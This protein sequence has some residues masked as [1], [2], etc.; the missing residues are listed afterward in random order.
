MDARGF[1]LIAK[2]LALAS[3]ELPPPGGQAAFPAPDGRPIVFLGAARDDR[4]TLDEAALLDAVAIYTRD[5]G[6][7]VLRSNERRRPLAEPSALAEISERLRSRNARLA[8]WCQTRADG[9]SVELVV[10]DGRRYTTREAFEKEGPAGPEIY[11]AIALKLRAALTGPE[12]PSPAAP[13][14]RDRADRNAAQPPIGRGAPPGP[15]GARDVT[16]SGAADRARPADAP[17]SAPR[18]LAPRVEPS[19]PSSRPEADP[20]PALARPASPALPSET[21]LAIGPAQPPPHLVSLAVGYALSRPSGSAPWRNA[22]AIHGV[23]SFH[24]R[25]EIDLGL[26]VAP[27]AE[28]DAPTGFVSVTDLPLRLGAR[29][30]RR[31]SVYLLAAGALVGV[32]ALFATATASSPDR[33]TESTRVLAASFGLELLARGPSVRGFAPEVRLFGEVNAPNTRF[34]VR[35]ATALESGALTVGLGL[36][37]AVPAP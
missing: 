32:H 1:A 7:T 15:E 8:F 31:S 22:A 12:P 18:P 13:P 11:R 19:I 30:V 26:E 5:L 33:A 21:S 4:P 36:G 25:A 16:A 34:R 6:V 17:R 23:A 37:I 9:R 27:A 14:N 3:D 20:A 35:G 24:Q 10:T 28:R 2:L 29:L